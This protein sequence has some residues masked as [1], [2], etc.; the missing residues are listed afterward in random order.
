MSATPELL[1]V[2]GQE[3]GLSISPLDRGFHFGDGLFETIACVRR[4]PRFLSLHLDRLSS[5][6]ARLH[7]DL[8]V[9]AVGHEVQHAAAATD[10][11]LIKLMVTRGPAVARGYAWSG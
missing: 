11:S 4:K 9:N 2:N 8:D 7:I 5:G 6:C 3:V 10:V 1:L